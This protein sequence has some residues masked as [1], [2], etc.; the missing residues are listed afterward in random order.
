M[1]NGDQITAPVAP[2]LT[3]AAGVCRL[4]GISRASVFNLQATGQLPAAVLRRGKIV[5]WSC[6]EIERWIS[7]G[8]PS[9]EVFE[10]HRGPRR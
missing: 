5:R 9:R 6:A 1:S 2:M 8:C 7:L 3:D 10:L 4:L